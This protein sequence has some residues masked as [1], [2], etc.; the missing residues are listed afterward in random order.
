MRKWYDCRTEHHGFSPGD[1]VLVLMPIVGSL[2]QA[3]Y[4]GPYNNAEKMSDL[5]YVVATAE[6]KK[7]RRLC[8]VNLLKPYHRC[9]GETD[10]PLTLKCPL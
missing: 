7:T 5:N 1:K 2:F 9:V 8:H 10:F 4:T 6:R 3:K